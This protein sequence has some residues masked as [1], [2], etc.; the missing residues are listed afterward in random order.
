MTR[1]WPVYA[2]VRADVLERTRRYQYV[3][4]VVVALLLGT[5]LVPGR[6]AGYETFLIDGYRGF[7]NSAWIGASYA[8][9]VALL[10]SLFGFYNVKSAVERDRTTR[11][12]EIV[13]T[14]P[15]GRFDYSL[16]K[17][18]SNFL[19]LGSM[20][21]I[22]CVTAVAM[23]FVRGESH[24][25]D[26]RPD[27][28]AVRPGRSSAD[29]NGRGDRAS[30]SRWFRGCA[31][32]LGTSRISLCGLVFGL[33][34]SEPAAPG[35]VVAR[36]ARSQSRDAAGVA[37]AARPWIRARMPSSV[38]IG[39]VVGRKTAPH[40]FT[41]AGFH[42]GA[43]DVSGR[44]V[45]FGVALVVVAVAALFFDRFCQAGA[46]RGAPAEQRARTALAVRARRAIARRCSTCSSEATSERSC[47]RSFACS[48]AA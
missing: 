20:T 13:A 41:F 5:L 28:C 11:V 36:H 44:L 17:A 18:L 33:E 38:E 10:L 23:Q 39:A 16:G 19:V 3:A 46:H 30:S 22:L 6:N 12:G 40:F 26:L 27:R 34:R 42:W 32:A 31:A 9:L 37:G 7:Y 48:C 21:A 24:A 8:V 15:I 29:G 14:T 25:L 1:L 47:S 43:G 35:A 4:T 2:L 45:W